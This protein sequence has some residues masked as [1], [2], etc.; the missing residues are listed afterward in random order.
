M[1]VELGTYLKKKPACYFVI[2]DQGF[3]YL[4]LVEGQGPVELG[5]KAFGPSKLGK[6]DALKTI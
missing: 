4:S 2:G 5:K 1:D 6:L 3:S